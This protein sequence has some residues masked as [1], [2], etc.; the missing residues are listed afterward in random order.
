MPFISTQPYALAEGI[1]PDG[2]AW[3]A[4]LQSGVYYLR[5]N[6]NVTTTVPVGYVDPSQQPAHFGALTDIS[7]TP[8]NGTV[9]TARG[10]AAFASGASAVTVTNSFVTATSQVACTLETIDGTLTQI[11]TCVPGAGTFTVTGN[12]N[13]TGTTKFS[14]VVMNS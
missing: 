2:S 12:A 1:N 4:Y 8:G 7:G 14:F 13:A 11:L 9:N 6:P 10:R 5:S 3:Q